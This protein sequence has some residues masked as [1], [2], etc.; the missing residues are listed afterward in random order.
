MPDLLPP[1]QPLSVDDLLHQ[2]LTQ[3][4]PYFVAQSQDALQQ[5]Q[6]VAQ[7]TDSTNP[8]IAA[9][10]HEAR[11]QIVF[12][13]AQQLHDLH[14]ELQATLKP[15]PSVVS[16]IIEGQVIGSTPTESQSLTP[17]PMEEPHE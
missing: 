17:L 8:R 16:I 3:Q 4:Q 1:H 5:L 9:L 15:T 7:Q 6:T 10:L 11:G 2:W 13:T 12:N 14:Q